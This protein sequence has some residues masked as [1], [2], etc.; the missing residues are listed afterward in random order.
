MNDASARI[1]TFH[2][3]ERDRETERRSFNLTYPS[4]STDYIFCFMVVKLTTS[5]ISESIAYSFFVSLLPVD[6]V[7]SPSPSPKR[8]ISLV[9]S[10]CFRFNL[11]ICFEEDF[12]SS[13]LAKIQR[14]QPHNY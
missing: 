9:A 8:I 2:L 1:A 12:V 10:S 14:D 3:R 5:L 4:F 7:V 11:I 6:E 13:I